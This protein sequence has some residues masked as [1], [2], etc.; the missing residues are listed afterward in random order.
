MQYFSNLIF[1]LL[2][3]I[4]AIPATKTICE[5]FSIE[6]QVYGSYM[7]WFISLML[8]IAL[9]PQ[10]NKSDLMKILPLVITVGVAAKTNVATGN[11][12][13]GNNAT[14]TNQ[15]SQPLQTPPLQTQTPPLLLQPSQTPKTPQIKQ[16]PLLQIKPPP[17]PLQPLQ[18]PPPPPPSNE[19]PIEY[20]YGS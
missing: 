2:L 18:T 16:L 19:L 11:N 3:I 4:I 20:F 13:T 9:L 14:N 12:A 8:F 10:D 7:L 1:T 17:P 15:P 5:F 6:P